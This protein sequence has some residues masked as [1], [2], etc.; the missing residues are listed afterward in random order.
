MMIKK[1]FL[2]TACCLLPGSA[3]GSAPRTVAVFP[4]AVHSQEKLDYLGQGIADM[5][6]TRMEEGADIVTVDKHTLRKA[7]PPEGG[8]LDE[9]LVRELA[10]SVGADYAI[11]G[12][13]T[14]I[15]AGVSI[16]ALIID[17]SGQK[18]N[19]QV[20]VRCDGIEGVPE[21]VAQLARQLDLTI[22]DKQI[23]GRIDIRGNRYI[24]KDAIILVLKSREGDLYSPEALQ[25]D[26]RLVYGM[27][28]FS[29]VRIESED[30]PEGKLVTFI[31]AERPVVSQ[32]KIQGN[33]QIKTPDIQKTL[34]VKLGRVLDQNQV[35]KDAEGIRKL[36]T[37]KGY[38]SAEI[39]YKLTPSGEGETSVDY[40]IRENEI[41]KIKKITFVGNTNIKSKQLRG[42]ME[43]RQK[44]FLSFITSA[45]IFKEEALQKDVEKLMAYYYYQ[46][47]IKA[48]VSN[49]TVTHEGKDIFISIPVEEGDRFNI[50]TV[51]LTGDLILPRESL[52]KD[53]QAI[54]G[55]VFSSNYLNKDMVNL[56][57]LYA[58][59]GYAN[60]DISPLTSIH[61]EQKTVD[62]T[63]DIA[64]GEKVYFEKINITGNNR[65]RDKVIRRE[66]R[67]AEGD[68]Y[69]T[70]K[71][72]RSQQELE[73][74]GY[75][76]K[77]NLTTAAGSSSSKLNLNVEVEEKPTGSISFGAGY[78]S[79]DSL[80]GMIQFSQENFRGKG[81]RFDVSA[82]LGGTNR[83][84][85]SFTEPWFRDTR[86]SAG[87]DLYNMERWYEDFDSEST[88]GGVR[89]GHPVG[90]Y[91]KFNFGYEYET[92]D[93]T[94]VDDDA[95][96]EILEQEGTTTVGAFNA[97]IIRNTLD[98]RFTPRKGTLNSIS[99]KFAGLGGDSSF[100]T[101]IASSSRY[102]PLPWE[103]AFMIRG[104][105]GYIFDYGGDEIPI[106]EKFFL[107][108]LDS[109]RGFEE[110]SVGPRVKRSEY[111]RFITDPNDYDV[112]GGEKELFF[113]FE[114]IF[115]IV[116][117]AG[118][119]GD[120]FFDTGN[121]YRQ[122]ESYFSD[123][124]KSV[125]AGIR[126]QSPFGPLRV[127]WGLNLSPK[128][129]EDS[130]QIHFTMGTMF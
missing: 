23:I 6:L 120:I 46:G 95:A 15:G 123:M 58:D 60:V 99:G 17:A 65:T 125:G 47:Y 12:S 29:D 118:I 82:Q 69:S 4:F 88:G 94:N 57:E 40:Y 109:L 97:G 52:A 73:N 25:E 19:R 103:T 107:G 126:W 68:L 71:I 121:A 114:Y 14:K 84:M 66:V 62:I 128:E 85:F 106:F 44:N 49:P 90:E 74:L 36:Y 91:T 27:G 32:I 64:Q 61:D 50:G 86:W 20:Y 42:I 119:R 113:N 37:D 43:T 8:A 116:K 63:Y 34:G 72:K 59:K 124:R 56:R 79:V 96:V 11:T 35:R 93:V 51:D 101:F 1:L 87:F 21:H 41:S 55:K 33:K 28:Y 92:V 77:V 104:T 105:I 10:R 76:K 22:L 80:V 48:T 129:D 81:Q 26:L 130:S 75:F 31:V 39:E 98:N 24:E 127:E 7:L 70:G 30:A 67:V 83:F 53:L 100:T 18:E 54:E 16:D 122:S 45:G 102:F 78:S 108:G 13:I 38:L 115:P 117:S 5:L 110:R 2:V 89:L 3:W 112:V 111:N 9:R